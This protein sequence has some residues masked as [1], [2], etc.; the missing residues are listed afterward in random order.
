VYYNCMHQV[1]S[2]TK[3]HKLFCKV[4]ERVGVIL[5]QI[6]ILINKDI[7]INCGI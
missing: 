3:W 5:E 2:A 1:E 7:N 6:Y 4:A